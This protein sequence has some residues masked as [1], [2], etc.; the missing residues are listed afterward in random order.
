MTPTNIDFNW[1]DDPTI[2][3]ALD[4]LS[5]EAPEGLADRTLVAIGLAEAYAPIET[6]I[7]PIWVARLSAGARAARA[8]SQAKATCRRGLSGT[9][10]STTRSAISS[11]QPA[12]AASAGGSSATA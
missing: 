11:Q 2:E 1:S 3:N 10:L 7:G 9:R 8:N 6:V 12:A 4:D 5:A